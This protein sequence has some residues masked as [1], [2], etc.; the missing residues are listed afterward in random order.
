MTTALTAVGHSVWRAVITGGDDA[1]VLH[2]NCSHPIAYA[3]G[4]HSDSHSNVHV[5]VFQSGL[6]NI[7]L[8]ASL[9]NGLYFDG[10]TLM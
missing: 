3:I 10:A 8:R 9:I 1:I 2:Q 4:T 6:S 7:D 5:V